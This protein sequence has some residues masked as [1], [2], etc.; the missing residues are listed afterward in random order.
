MK[1][2]SVYSA[3]VDHLNKMAPYS[4]LFTFFDIGVRISSDSNEFIDL[5]QGVYPHFVALPDSRTQLSCYILINSSADGPCILFDDKTSTVS[6][7]LPSTESIICYAEIMLFKKIFDLLDNKLILHAGV[8]E[9]DNAGYIF[10][11]PSGIGKT[12]LMVELIKR[13]YRF[14]SDE[15]CVLNLDDFTLLP[16]PRRLGIKKNSMLYNHIDVSNAYYFAFED[17]YFVDCNAVRQRCIGDRCIPAC[18]I[19]LTDDVTAPGGEYNS[20][21]QDRSFIDVILIND[22]T[23][24]INKL[25]SHAGVTI[26]E[27][28]RIDCYISY[29]LCIPHRKNVLM[30]FHNVC[31]AYDHDIVGIYK[32]NEKVPDYTKPAYLKKISSFESIVHIVEH[33]VN[34]APTAAVT[35]RYNGKMLPLIM[36][37]SAMFKNVSSYVLQAGTLTSMGDIVDSL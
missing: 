11:A 7:P 6:Y 29:R 12:T 18:V 16:F 31:A 35:R 4:C 5:V 24:L 10:Y 14:L 9:K 32:D 15:F 34:R 2:N 27:K 22:N 28:K 20:Q 36:E 37:L 26:A 3:D 19:E 13:G 21:K 33:M 1:K 30:S 23:E 25:T 17:K 8:V